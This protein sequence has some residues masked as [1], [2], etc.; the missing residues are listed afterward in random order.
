MKKRVNNILMT[1]SIFTSIFALSACNG[2]VR[3]NLGLRKSSPNE[4]RV[5]ANPPLS[6]PPEFSL[7][8]PVAESEFVE[9]E[10]ISTQAKNIMFEQS[11]YSSSDYES[12]PESLFSK[13]FGASEA[14]PK[15][16]SLLAADELSSAKE[17]E[18]KGILA[19]I[20][21][22]SLS[23]ANESSSIVDAAL[24][25]KRISE[26]IKKGEDI[27]TGQT[28]TLDSSDAERSFLDRILGR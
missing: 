25:K 22:A 1:L 13:N 26:N 10:D 5:V 24:E 8:P 21:P 18:K 9:G 6:V 16:K 4:F 11:S 23:K 7:R 12:K 27:T 14:D 2:S 20:T 17:A 3:D 19:K 15:I 28:P